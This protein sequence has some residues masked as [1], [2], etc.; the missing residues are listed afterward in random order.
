MTDLERLKESNIWH[1]EYDLP[2]S[3]QNNN[4]HFYLALTERVTGLQFQGYS[5]YLY[6]C[7][8]DRGLYK[9]WP[10]QS[11]SDVTS[12][13]E[14]IGICYLNQFAAQDIYDYLIKN[15]GEYNNT[16]HPPTIPESYNLNRFPWFIQYVKHRAGVK[17]TLLSQLVW[18]LHIL[19]D[20]IKTQKGTHDA[21]GRL[22]IWVMSDHMRDLPLCRLAI[23]TWNWRMNLIEVTPKAMLLLEPKE[24]PILSE[25][26]PDKFS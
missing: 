19:F 16:P 3:P 2:L 13:D 18:A 4:P 15:D 10:K 1:P 20:L 24:N 11:S 22:L 21:S 14:L 9:R 23:W 26:A 12:Q 17:L 25:L 6:N 8:K 5:S 7:T